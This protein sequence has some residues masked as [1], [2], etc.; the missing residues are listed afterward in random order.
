MRLRLTAEGA[1]GALID[2]ED[3]ELVVP[4]YTKVG[5][6][7]T[8][9]QIF[10]ART[11]RELQTIRQAAGATPTTSRDFSR[12][13][14]LLLRFKA[15]GPGGTAPAVTV[16]LLNSVGETMSTLPPAEVRPDGTM[17]LPF[18]LGG[19]V[20]GTYIIEIEAASSDLKSRVAIGFRI[21]N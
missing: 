7:V 18:S 16:R 4:D 1:G 13:E 9:P 2:S 10:R 8:P 17:D 19:L 5:P 3:K 6:T 14:Q 11:A 20:T 12:T 21:S 15:Y